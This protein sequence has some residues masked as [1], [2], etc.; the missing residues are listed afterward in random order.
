M[1]K[2]T[3]SA[4]L[5]L[6]V[7]AAALT[8]R[9][10]QAQGAGLTIGGGFGTLLGESRNISTNPDDY[11]HRL[12]FAT[13]RL[14]LTG[15][16]L[17]GERLWPDLPAHEEARAWVGSVVLS[18]PL[19]PIVP[20]AMAGW[21]DYNFGDPDRSRW[22]AGFGTRLNLGSIGLFAEASRYNRLESDLFTAG[23][24]VHLGGTR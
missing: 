19:G 23:L 5:L 20:Y 11:N 4:I 22:S 15:L 21:G 24:L 2:Q 1:K 9:S 13:L 17:R 6:C 18:F 7:A 14:P 12:I 3:L 10:A 8:G 16:E